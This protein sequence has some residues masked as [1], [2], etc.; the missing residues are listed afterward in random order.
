MEQTLRFL[1][2]GRRSGHCKELKLWRTRR[3]RENSRLVPGVGVQGHGWV[4]GQD[5]E[6]VPTIF[7]RGFV[8]T[9]LW[10]CYYKPGSLLSSYTNCIFIFPE[11]YEVPSMLEKTTGGAERLCR[12]PE[13]TRYKSE[14]KV[15][16]VLLGTMMAVRSVRRERCPMLN[17]SSGCI[18]SPATSLSRQGA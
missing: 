7:C 2:M 18:P 12:L 15:V 11:T 16:P 8:R 10:V 13:V 1:K 17:S 4:T 5:P 6:L 14:P 3:V 9:C